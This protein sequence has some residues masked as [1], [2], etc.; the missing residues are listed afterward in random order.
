M[1]NQVKPTTEGKIILTF[2]YRG[3]ILRTSYS[4][5]KNEI[6]IHYDAT[7]DLKNRISLHFWE[8]CGYFD[9]NHKLKKKM[10]AGPALLRSRAL[11]TYLITPEF[12]IYIK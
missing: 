4:Y 7:V 10:G 3:S 6:L 12:L 11:T 2:L 5:I 8:N 9:K 1:V